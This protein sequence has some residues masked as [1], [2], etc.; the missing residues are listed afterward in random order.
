MQF[1]EVP[2][3]WCTNFIKKAGYVHI[4]RHLTI[5]YVLPTWFDIILNRFAPCTSTRYTKG[6]TCFQHIVNAVQKNE[7]FCIMNPDVRKKK[8]RLYNEKN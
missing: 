8:V 6:L 4:A 1:A 3:T 2:Q 5:K 7:W